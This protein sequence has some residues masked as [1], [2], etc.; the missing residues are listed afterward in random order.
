MSLLYLLLFLEI[1]A[2]A[3]ACALNGIGKGSVDFRT[4]ER[5]VNCHQQPFSQSRRV[6][7]TLCENLEGGLSR[8]RV[9]PKYRAVS[10]RPERRR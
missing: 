8:F 2:L 3:T 7:E 6:I 10:T 9:K 4:D 5:Q 1:I